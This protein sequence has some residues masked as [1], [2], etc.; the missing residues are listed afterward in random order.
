MDPHTDWPKTARAHLVAHRGAP[1]PA[2]PRPP[3]NELH[4]HLAWAVAGSFL[5]LLPDLA[6]APGLAGLNA[7]LVARMTQV[8]AHFAPAARGVPDATLPVLDVADE[9]LALALARARGALAFDRSLWPGVV[10]RLFDG[11]GARFACEVLV[12]AGGMAF[13]LEGDTWRVHTVGPVGEELAGFQ[14]LRERLAHAAEPDFAEAR[15]FA[16]AHRPEASAAVREKL[17][18]TFAEPIWAAE[19]LDASL[20]RLADD[21]P[22]PASTLALLSVLPN[23]ESAM[24]LVS[25]AVARFD[26]HASGL[27]PE[28]PSPSGLPIERWVDQRLPGLAAHAFDHAAR[29]GD[30]AVPVLATLLTAAFDQNEDGPLLRRLGLALSLF[31]T[32][33]AAEAMAER[34]GRKDLDKLTTEYFRAHPALAVAHLAER[35]KRMSKI[36]QHARTLVE[37]AERLLASRPVAAPVAINERAGGASAGPVGRPPGGMSINERAGGASGGPVGRQ[38]GGVSINER[39]GGASAGPVG[40]QPGGVSINDRAG[41]A[42]AGPVGRPPGGVSINERAGGASAGPVGRPPGGMSIP[43]LAILPVPL[44][45]LPWRRKK[46]VSADGGLDPR[47]FENLPEKLPATPRWLVLDALPPPR[48]GDGT[49]LPPASVEHLVEMLRFTRAAAPYVGVEMVRAALEPASCIAFARALQASFRANDH[50][51]TDFWPVRALGAFGGAEV[52]DN[53]L[54]LL[55]EDGLDGGERTEAR[56]AAAE[57][58]LLTGSMDAVYFAFDRSRSLGSPVAR[59]DVRQVLETE[60][61]RRGC[62]LQSLALGCIPTLGFDPHGRRPLVA[63]PPCTVQLDSVLDPRLVDAVGARLTALPAAATPEERATLKTLTR[64][65]TQ[66]AGTLLHWLED[67]LL[68]QNGAIPRSTLDRLAAHPLAGP[69]VSNLLWTTRTG[70]CFRVAEDRSLA[71]LEDTSLTLVDDTPV[72]LAHAAELTAAERVS[73]Q[74]VWAAYELI[75]PIAQLDRPLAADGSRFEALLGRAADLGVSER[76]FAL[77]Y[78][79]E[80]GVSRRGRIGRLGRAF[81]DHVVI[82]RFSPPLRL[83]NA[84]LETLEVM[85]VDP[86][87]ARRA[88]TDPLHAAKG[89]TPAALG[90]LSLR[91]R[92]EL[93]VDLT[94]LVQAGVGA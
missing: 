3:V 21:A 40:R 24:R 22:V 8:V 18:Y 36:G 29:L 81:G 71:T 38:P 59:A 74:E 46:R 28:T 12:G 87:D 1:G 33:A 32:A 86:A 62:D 41:G 13:T 70:L 56:R 51:R 34:L 66:V 88:R 4:G 54:A 47:L 57:G 19:A 85:H 48:L 55:D 20:A 35:A 30:A 79:P 52:I 16:E 90:D 80:G 53:L 26:R 69:L 61:A 43:A 50:K 2:L 94:R 27:A 76:L 14:A 49:P 60:A 17:A 68:S 45:R 58:L 7:A 73:W 6:S 39:A 93:W 75:A 37:E 31:G 25:T 78:L 65:I 67:R 11:G 10:A 92:S 63:S 84:A 77:G 89:G 42:S 82:T 83:R 44:A 9:Q 72:T 64:S 15:A 91:E 23:A 5:D